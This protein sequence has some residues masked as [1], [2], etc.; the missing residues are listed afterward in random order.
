M[1]KPLRLGRFFDFDDANGEILIFGKRRVTVDIDGLC[2]HL[3]GLVGQRAARTI[4]N[5]H[6]R[7]SGKERVTELRETLK[8]N[9]SPPTFGEIVEALTEGEVLA[10]YGVVKLRMREDQVVPVELE[11]RN[12][13]VKAATGTVVTFILSYW[14]GAFEALLNKTLDVTNVT[15]DADTDT[16]KCQFT[17]IGTPITD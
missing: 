5:N 13:I 15:Y 10:G 1:P 7:Q 6:G 11:M 17:V 12:P 4:A 16:L 8:G 2:A 3:E 14:T 9:P